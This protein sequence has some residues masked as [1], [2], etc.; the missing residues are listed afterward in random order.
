LGKGKNGRRQTRERI[1]RRKTGGVERLGK[2]KNR[3]EK[4]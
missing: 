4:N 3:E 1:R 2:G